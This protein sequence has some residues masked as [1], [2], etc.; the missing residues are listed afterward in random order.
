MSFS[1][2]KDPSMESCPMQDEICSSVPA[3]FPFPFPPYDIQEEFMKNLYVVL[4]RGGIGIFESPTGTV[5]YL[6]WKKM[7]SGGEG[8]VW[9][10][11]M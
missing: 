10:V 3:Y 4:E 1:A 2:T 8:G 6:T 9:A 7:G 11:R 5:S